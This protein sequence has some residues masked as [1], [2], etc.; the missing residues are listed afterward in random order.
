VTPGNRSNI[1]G[2]FSQNPEWVLDLPM[3]SLS[4]LKVY[5]ALRLFSDG[6]GYVRSKSVEK[7]AAR[8]RVSETMAKTALSR[9]RAMGALTSHHTSVGGRITGSV[10]QLPGSPPET[11]SN[12]STF[13]QTRSRPRAGYQPST[14]LDPA[15]STGLDPAPS[16]GLDPALRIATRPKPDPNQTQKPDPWGGEPAT[17]SSIPGQDSMSTSA[18]GHDSPAKSTPGQ[19]AHRINGVAVTSARYDEIVSTTFE[20]WLLTQGGRSL[21]LTKSRQKA[22]EHALAQFSA[23]DVFDAVTGWTA[24]PWIDRVKHSDLTI[25]L[26]SPEQIEK[27]RDLGRGKFAKSTQQP[28][29]S[30]PWRDKITQHDDPIWRNPNALK[31]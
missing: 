30:T 12:G 31:F 14:G 7:I 18:A 24:D 21:L 27:F 28:V 26:R 6:N 25:L 10:Y 23:E 19:N 2:A 20:A 16:T 22:I 1:V 5:S 4:E 8:A 13:R 15:P 29:S 3:T 9:L 17:T 11:P